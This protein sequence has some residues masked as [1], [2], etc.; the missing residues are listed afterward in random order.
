MIMDFVPRYKAHLSQRVPGIQAVATVPYVGSRLL[1]T[2][3]PAA[4]LVGGLDTGVRVAPGIRSGMI[5]VKVIGRHIDPGAF[6]A[7]L[8]RV[9][10]LI[11]GYLAAIDADI[12]AWRRQLADSLE[13]EIVERFRFLIEVERSKF[14]V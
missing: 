14:L 5:E 2:A 6:S 11:D 7:H 1:M 3:T 4:H 8:A 12:S 13:H 9:R 10:L